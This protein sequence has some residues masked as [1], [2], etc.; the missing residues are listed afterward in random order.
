[1]ATPGLSES[2][3][4]CSTSFYYSPLP[5]PTDL[6]CRLLHLSPSLIPASVHGFFQFKLKSFYLLI[7]IF[8]LLKNFLPK[9]NYKKLNSYLFFFET[10]IKNLIWQSNFSN[11]NPFK[12]KIQQN[13][14]L[15]PSAL[16]LRHFQGYK[17]KI[18]TIYTEY[19]FKYCFPSRRGI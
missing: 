8:L 19:P 11:I 1:M 18:M 13:H 2:L 9:K 7:Y 5:P 12:N 10:I 15:V 17:T 4:S 6:L 3:D 14:N 16:P